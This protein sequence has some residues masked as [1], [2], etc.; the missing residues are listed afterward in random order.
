MFAFVV[1]DLVFQYYADRLA[2]KNVSEMTYFVRLYV[3]PCLPVAVN[4]RWTP[5]SFPLMPVDGRFGPKLARWPVRLGTFSGV[6]AV[7]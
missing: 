4:G 3:Y 6:T 2:G 1:L 5:W 7:D